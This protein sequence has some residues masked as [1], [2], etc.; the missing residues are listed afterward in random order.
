MQ[1]AESLRSTV[2][3]WRLDDGSSLR[4]FPQVILALTK[5]R[6]ADPYEFVAR[7]LE[8]RRKV[9]ASTGLI[10]VSQCRTPLALWRRLHSKLEHSVG[11]MENDNGNGALSPISQT[12]QGSRRP[13][14][15]NDAPASAATVAAAA[16][17]APDTWSPAAERAVSLPFLSRFYETH[18]RPL[19]QAAGRRLSTG[20]V[21]GAV[22]MPQTQE[23]ACRYSDLPG[24]AEGSLWNPN[25]GAD[26]WFVSHAF[27]APF[28]L[29]VDALTAHFA[30]LGA[31]PESV[32]V[33]LVR[34]GRARS[35]SL[36]VL[37]MYPALCR[38]AQR[39]Q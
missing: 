11:A 33:W 13:A 27:A 8:S 10:I 28:H 19:E 31:T 1:G 4:S 20:E 36:D 7:E 17:A 16:P 35:F 18:V 15:P 2:W 22:I 23:L 21:V 29:L 9:Q 26:L 34:M 6:P 12:T 25:G 14:G 39:Q 38:V 32:F 5:S 3:T 30:A 24:T 37:D